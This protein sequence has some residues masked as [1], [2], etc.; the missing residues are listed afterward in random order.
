M[1]R[2]TRK[3]VVAVVKVDSLDVVEFDEG[4]MLVGFFEEK[5][6]D[7]DEVRGDDDDDDNDDDDVAAAA[8]D[9]VLVEQEDVVVVMA[10]EH[11]QSPPIMII[12]VNPLLWISP[13]GAIKM[14]SGSKKH[15]D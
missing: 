9:V 15:E 12:S 5:M 14:A 2:V 10:V 6:P 1:E 4:L 8:E 11:E 13:W 7:V 3:S